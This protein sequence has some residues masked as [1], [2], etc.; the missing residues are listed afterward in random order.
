MV[1]ES[2]AGKSTLL[3]RG[4]LPQLERDSAFLPAY[5]S[6]WGEDWENDV[7]ES[8][9]RMLR[10]GSD[11]ADL[12]TDGLIPW[13]AAQ[14]PK[15]RVPVLLFDQF[16]DYITRHRSRFLPDKKG[17]RV[18]TVKELREHNALWDKLARLVEDGSIHC[19]FAVR[20]DMQW[21]LDCARFRPDSAT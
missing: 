5:L 8:L 6:Y 15:G 16:D 3:R 2:G 19:L 14:R 4:V 20:Q 1:G 13:L 17:G 12:T 21:G 18:L 9:T 7:R 10:K 11:D